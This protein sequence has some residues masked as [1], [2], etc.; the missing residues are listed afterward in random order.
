MEMLESVNVEA[1]ELFGEMIA[2]L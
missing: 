1:K 2:T